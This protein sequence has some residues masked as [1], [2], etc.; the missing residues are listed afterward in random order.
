[1]NLLITK[2]MNAADIRAF[3]KR[4][5]IVRI[6]FRKI[7]GDERTMIATTDLQLIPVEAHPFGGGTTHNY[8]DSYPVYDLHK[9]AWRAFKPS[10]LL[11][12]EALDNINTPSGNNLS[13]FA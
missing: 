11:G 4:H 9:Q 10:N 8:T 12:L 5:P 3:F 2:T 7:N 1:M 6:R 13:L